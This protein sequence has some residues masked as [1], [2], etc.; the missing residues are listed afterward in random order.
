[1]C[2]RAYVSI[3]SS[4]A[5]VGLGLS[6][7]FL[8][9]TQ[10]VGLLRRGISPSQSHYL[11]TE[12]H[13]HRIKAQRRPCLEWDSNPRCSVRATE[14]GSCL[15][16]GTHTATSVVRKNVVQFFLPHDLLFALERH[17]TVLC[18]PTV[19]REMLDV[20]TS[21]SEDYTLYSTT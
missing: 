19:E 11:H 14:D 12:Q 1:M 9:Y 21:E 13:K 5:L 15:R 3:C 8:I 10:S 20:V 18:S 7:S 2:N 6:F 17:P 16:L 4:T